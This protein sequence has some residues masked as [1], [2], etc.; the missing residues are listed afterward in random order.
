[1]GARADDPHARQR[2]GVALEAIEE[3]AR[4]DGDAYSVS[5]STSDAASVFSGVKPGLAV[6]ATSRLRSSSPAPASSTSAR[7]SSVTASP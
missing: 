1:M 4:T 6:T 7:A 5:G 2:R 3:F